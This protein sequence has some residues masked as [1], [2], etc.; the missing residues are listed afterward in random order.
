MLVEYRTGAGFGRQWVDVWSLYFYAYINNIIMHLYVYLISTLS[1]VF[2]ATKNHL[3]IIHNSH[4]IWG[5]GAGN[6]CPHILVLS[7]NCIL[8]S[9][10]QCFMM[11]MPLKMFILYVILQN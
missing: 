10:I 11:V 6:I 9:N 2:F 8:S 1:S 7:F 3:C 5:F 4:V